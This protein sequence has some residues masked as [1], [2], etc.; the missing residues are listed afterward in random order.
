[1]LSGEPGDSV[2]TDGFI[3]DPNA[4]LNVMTNYLGTGY[5]FGIH[6][7]AET[8]HDESKFQR[9]VHVIVISDSDMFTML[10]EKGSG[11]IGWDV[12]RETLPI[13]KEGALCVADH[14][15][16]DKLG[17]FTDIRLQRMTE[18]GWNVHLVDSMEEF[19]RLRSSVQSHSICS[20]SSGVKQEGPQLAL[21]ASLGRMQSSFV[22]CAG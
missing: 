15:A 10:N 19:R 3:R 18:E 13:C 9:P 16:K 17:Q 12:A 6:R 20:R 11:R 1:M 2:S 22:T 5:A 4:C 14:G 21:A 8:F 7:L